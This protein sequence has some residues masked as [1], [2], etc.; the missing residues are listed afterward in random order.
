MAK[1]L[2]TIV[3]AHTRKQAMQAGEYHSKHRKHHEVWAD[4]I[5]PG[6]KQNAPGKKF[7]DR[8]LATR[9]AQAERAANKIAYAPS[10]GRGIP[11]GKWNDPLPTKR[12]VREDTDDDGK[13][14]MGRKGKNGMR[15]GVWKNRGYPPNSKKDNKQNIS[16]HDLRRDWHPDKPSLKEDI[17]AIL[18]GLP[19]GAWGEWARR[20]IEADPSKT[21][22]WAA[23]ANK[24]AKEGKADP[25]IR[26]ARVRGDKKNMGK[27]VGSGGHTKQG[28]L[29]A[30]KRQRVGY[31]GPDKI[32]RQKAPK[33]E[34][35][36]KLSMGPS[37]S[38][39]ADWE[40]PKGK[41]KGKK[42]LNELYGKGRIKDIEDKS[43]EGFNKVYASSKR[44]KK[45]GVPLTLKD[46]GQL[47]YHDA[48]L[49]RAG[50]LDSINYWNKKAKDTPDYPGAVSLAGRL[51]RDAGKGMNRGVYGEVKKRS[52]KFAKY[53]KG[54]K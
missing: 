54:I 40:K 34:A 31:K 39:R 29:K 15:M 1:T 10:N 8:H 4:F 52:K 32:T 19:D 6:I 7:T 46:K 24:N 28:Y 16:W 20:R 3:E 13:Y 35:K 11:Q 41:K 42:P 21:G 14:Y 2:R 30:L 43:I 17:E 33:K 9:H 51:R 38:Y 12:T 22:M 44:K 45:L 26:T 37:N 27:A 49:D 50:Y 18:E 5:E 23:I 53:V 36:V 48:T 25:K 47:K